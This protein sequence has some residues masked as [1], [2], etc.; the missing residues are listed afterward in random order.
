[1]KALQIPFSLIL[2]RFGCAENANDRLTDWLIDWPVDG[3]WCIHC[4]LRF[5]FPTRIVIIV[6]PSITTILAHYHPHNHTHTSLKSHFTQITHFTPHTLSHSHSHPSLSLIPNP[7]PNPP[8]P[9]QQIQQSNQSSL[10]LHST[11]TLHHTNKNFI[12]LSLTSGHKKN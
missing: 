4:L 10:A 1:M 7:N 11:H 12:L 2:R 8:N 5:H 3:G 9:I 6:T